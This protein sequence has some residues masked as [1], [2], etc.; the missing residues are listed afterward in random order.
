[1]AFS[2]PI[3]FFFAQPL[4]LFFPTDRSNCKQE[5]PWWMEAWTFYK[6]LIYKMVLQPWKW[7]YYSL[8]FYLM[9]AFLRGSMQR[10]NYFLRAELN[11]G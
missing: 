7:Y 10:S 8:A 9:K 4:L 2:F 5:I 11:W 6:V 3:E 1:M